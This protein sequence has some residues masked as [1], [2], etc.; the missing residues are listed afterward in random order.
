LACDGDSSTTI[1]WAR[2]RKDL[3]VENSVKKKKKE[4][5]KKKMKKKKKL[6]WGDILIQS[7][8]VLHTLLDL[9]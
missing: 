7:L 1:K 8:V 6:S 5:E 2:V 9:E 3:N 4:E